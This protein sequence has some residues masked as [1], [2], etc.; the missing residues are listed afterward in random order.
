ME[1]S[2][3]RKDYY[4]I[5]LK[6]EINE[7]FFFTFD[8]AEKRGAGKDEGKG[9]GAGGCEQGQGEGDEGAAGQPT[10]GTPAEHREDQGTRVSTGP[11]LRY[12]LYN[13]VKT[14]AR[15]LE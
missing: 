8:V 6:K 3:S 2:N 15:L 13:T 5:H 12:T 14:P 1:T 10:A 11:T 9:G 7:L 4:K